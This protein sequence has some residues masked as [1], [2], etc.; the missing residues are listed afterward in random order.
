L[1]KRRKKKTAQRKAFLP[2]LFWKMPR[3]R[4]IVGNTLEE[5]EGL[6]HNGVLKAPRSI[7]YSLLCNSADYVVDQTFKGK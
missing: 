3:E 1:K 5:R 6:K 4:S 2:C 7:M